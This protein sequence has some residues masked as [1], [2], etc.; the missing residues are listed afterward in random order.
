MEN[1]PFNGECLTEYAVY[2]A[3]VEGEGTLTMNDIPS[4]LLNGDITVR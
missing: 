1:C 2:M 4:S 3:E